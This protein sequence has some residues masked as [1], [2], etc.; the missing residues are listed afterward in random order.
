MCDIF[1]IE[2]FK[3]FLFATSLFRFSPSDICAF[4]E[5]ETYLLV[6][7]KEINVDQIFFLQ[8]KNTPIKTITMTYAHGCEMLSC[9]CYS[10][11]LN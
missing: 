7:E 8:E 9:N 11:V 3:D 5:I 2:F 1:H 6:V 4:V 10:H